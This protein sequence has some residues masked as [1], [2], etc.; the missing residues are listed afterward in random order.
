MVEYLCKVIEENKVIV[1]LFGP[2]EDSQ[3]FTKWEEPETFLISS[4]AF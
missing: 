1:S 3:G 2:S 4:T